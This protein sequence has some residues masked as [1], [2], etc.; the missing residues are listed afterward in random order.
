MKIHRLCMHYIIVLKKK[1]VFIDISWLICILINHLFDSKSQETQE[2]VKYLQ[3]SYFSVE[4]S[5]RELETLLQRL[6]QS[7][8]FK[9][10]N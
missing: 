4:E 3:I 5:N 7:M 8:K 9:Q 6:Q 10:E 2:F 1:N